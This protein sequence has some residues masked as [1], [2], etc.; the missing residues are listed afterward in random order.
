[1]S[2][3]PLR[4]MKS[5]ENL[6]EGTKGGDSFYDE[7]VREFLYSGVKY[8]VVKDL[9][10]K[11]LTVYLSLKNRSKKRK[12]IVNVT[13]RNGK[14]YLERLDS[15][16]QA[17]LLPSEPNKTLAT[18]YSNENPT[19]EVITLLNT[20]LVKAKCP[21]CKT[22]NNKDSRVCIDCRSNLYS[23]EPEYQN[24]LEKM[25]VLERTLNC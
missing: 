7:I 5:I 21:R 3:K 10:K 12:G 24:A 14:V 15:P 2:E 4:F 20:A 6:P 18:S 23:T 16:Q 13:T 8:A 22:L 17:K 1:M 11:P 19:F 9:G 25:E